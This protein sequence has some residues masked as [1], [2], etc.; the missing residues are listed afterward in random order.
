MSETYLDSSI[1]DGSLEISGYCLIRSDHPSNKK[2]GGI[3]IYYKNFLPLKLTCVH[4]LDECIAFDLVI[5]NKL[6]SFVALYRSPSQS[7]DNFETFPDNFEMTLDLVS[8]KNS[9]LLV[10]LGDFNAKLSQ[11][12]DKDSS[13]FEG[14]SVESMTSQSGLHQIIN[15]LT[16]HILEIPPRVLTSFLLRN[17]IYQSNQE[18][19]PHS[20]LTV[21]IRL[22]S[23]N[24]ILKPF[25]HHL[26]L[27]RFGTIK[28][29]VLILSDDPLT[30]LTGIKL[31][32]I[33]M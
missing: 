20:T 9:F 14:I 31:L 12:H 10:V 30:N 29:Q 7:Q 6:C 16:T 24:L 23:S 3:C 15:E 17:L 28:I 1:D 11:W 19:S 33:N 18:L 32:R 22:F 27:A 13:T 4:L 26:T 2:R 5:S 21:T 8:K 25:T